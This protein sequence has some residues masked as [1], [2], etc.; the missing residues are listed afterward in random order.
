MLSLP[1]S[2]E[3]SLFRSAIN[4]YIKIASA[5]SS[6]V[7]YTYLPSR[8]EFLLIFCIKIRQS[9]TQ[10]NSKLYINQSDMKEQDF[11]LETGF[12]TEEQVRYHILS[13]RSYVRYQLNRQGNRYCISLAFQE[14]MFTINT[15]YDTPP[16]CLLE[17]A[18]SYSISKPM[19][20]ELKVTSKSSA[21]STVPPRFTRLFSD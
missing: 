1:K 6:I 13:N 15:L 3:Y 5:L 12:S 18:L 14:F 17:T 11:S 7:I 21:S 4:T 9:K 19:T 2:T 8:L 16:S 10:S 20:S